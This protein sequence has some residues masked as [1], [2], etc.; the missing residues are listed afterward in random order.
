MSDG[1]KLHPA[2]NV[3]RDLRAR[4]RPPRA[5]R[6]AAGLTL[7][8][9]AVVCGGA[10]PNAPA[11]SGQPAASTPATSPT[12]SY[13]EQNGKLSELDFDRNGDGKVD[14]RAYMD[15]VL[16]KSIE[17][18]RDGNGK[19]DRWEYYEPVMSGS[20]P[21]G[22][23]DG[24]S[25]IVRAEEANAKN[26]RVNRR[27]FYSQGLIARVEEDT[28]S[29]GRIDKWETYTDGLVATV[30]LDLKHRGRPERRLVYR[31]DG[32]LERV[33]TNLKDAPASTS[34]LPASPAKGAGRSGQAASPNGKGGGST[35]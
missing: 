29:D 10:P 6:L 14:T 20:A 22:S 1:A 25:V 15:G 23:P 9:G 16:V 28:N 31:P 12:A 2:S 17:I 18:D 21:A 5:L 4:A 13:N 35:P 33:V 8:I 34:S 30:D 26:G 3:I 27:E 7:A 24:H 19:T 32:S 11:T